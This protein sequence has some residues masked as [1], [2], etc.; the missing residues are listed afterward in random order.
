[1]LLASFFL[2]N[3]EF[4]CDIFHTWSR[5]AVN[6]VDISAN[7]IDVNGAIEQQF[8]VFE[9]VF[10]GIQ[11]VASADDVVHEV[12]AETAREHFFLDVGIPVVLRVAEAVHQTD[13]GSSE[14]RRVLDDNDDAV[15][16]QVLRAQLLQQLLAGAAVHVE[17]DV[18][19]QNGVHRVLDAVPVLYEH[20]RDR[21]FHAG[22]LGVLEIGRQCLDRLV[23]RFDGDELSKVRQQ[24][25]DELDLVFSAAWSEGHTRSDPAEIHFAG[26]VVQGAAKHRIVVVASAVRVKQA[27][28][29][30]TASRHF[31]V[32]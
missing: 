14:R 3:T 7:L 19:S 8:N 20:L 23:V 31:S 21:R 12:E 32:Q 16:I 22:K 29:A 30:V 11:Q 26:Q 6:F 17:D 27:I 13:V 28:V 15:W 1:M 9:N 18:E 25:S 5:I 2:E 24:T 4:P 10:T